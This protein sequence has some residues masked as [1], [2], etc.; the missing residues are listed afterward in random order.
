VP[1]RFDIRAAA[2]PQTLPRILG[3]MAQRWIVPCRVVATT[4]AG[5]MRIV[6]ETDGLDVDA[7]A[8]LAAKIGTM[9]LVGEVGVS[10]RGALRVV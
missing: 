8:I 9:V 4:E 3:L 6:V 1:C 2:D 5:E 10:V 7:A